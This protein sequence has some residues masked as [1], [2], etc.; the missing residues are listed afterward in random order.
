ML[1]TGGLGLWQQDCQK[2]FPQEPEGLDSPWTPSRERMCQP[3]D[4][5]E[6][7]WVQ[8]LARVAQAALSLCSEYTCA[9][10]AAE[11]RKRTAAN[12][13][14]EKAWV[15]GHHRKSAQSLVYVSIT[16]PGRLLFPFL[17][18]DAETA[19]LVLKQP[20]PVGL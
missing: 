19:P 10:S 9:V 18:G 15:W 5:A 2:T 20:A 11:G 8:C 6:L 3:T 13:W 12:P 16:P 14:Q 4:A 7:P 17:E 1:V